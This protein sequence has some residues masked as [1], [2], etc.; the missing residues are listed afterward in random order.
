LFLSRFSF[1]SAAFLAES[2]TTATSASAMLVSPVAI[3][4]LTSLAWLAAFLGL[5][6][7]T[8]VSGVL[9]AALAF[10]N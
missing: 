3:A 2:S 4:L 10:E 6:F 5:G 7:F 9:A 1:V 8:G